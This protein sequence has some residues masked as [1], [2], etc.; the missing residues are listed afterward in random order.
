[1]SL[2]LYMDHHVHVAVTDGLRRRGVDVLTPFE[3][4]TADWDDERLLERATSLGRILF[5]QDRDFLALA[6]H[7]QQTGHEFSGVVYGHQLSLPIGRAV[8]DLHLIAAACDPEE[9]QN[10]IEFVPL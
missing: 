5:T 4:G 3:D 1:M 6:R 2:P 10:R 9:L 7:R 8:R